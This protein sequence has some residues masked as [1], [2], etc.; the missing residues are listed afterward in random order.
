MNPFLV[1]GDNWDPVHGRD[2]G[3]FSTLMGEVLAMDKTPTAEA[4]YKNLTSALKKHIVS[5]AASPMDQQNSEEWQW[6]SPD[7]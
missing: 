7:G 4:E 6:H 1:S 3:D 5:F 2:D